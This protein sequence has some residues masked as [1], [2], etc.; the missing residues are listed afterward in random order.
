MAASIRAAGSDSNMFFVAFN[1]GALKK[2]GGGPM[3]PMA[4]MGVFPEIKSG[5]VMFSDGSRI[6]GNVALDFADDAS[7]KTAKDLLDTMLGALRMTAPQQVKMMPAGMGDMAIKAL[8]KAR[9][10]QSGA[11]ITVPI[12]VETTMG[13][14]AEKLP[15]LMGA[16]AFGGGPGPGF[17]P[18]PGIG[19]GPG[20]GGPGQIPQPKMPT[21][22]KK[23]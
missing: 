13:D 1:G 20:M 8:D 12:E 3:G 23:L 18:G 4:M 15:P 7:A 10:T 19:P 11:T 22:K 5:R 6:T 2:A 21:K 17:G 14:L 9:P 16:M